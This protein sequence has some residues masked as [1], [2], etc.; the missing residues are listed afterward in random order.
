MMST[1]PVNSSVSRK[2][3]LL[4]SMWYLPVFLL[5][6]ISMVIPGSSIGQNVKPVEVV[7][8]LDMSGSMWRNRP[9]KSVKAIFAWGSELASGNDR[10]GV[11]TLGDKGRVARELEEVG[12][13][14]IRGLMHVL[15][16]RSNRTDVAAGLEQAYYMLKTTSRPGAKR[17][18][19]L[20]S[21]GRID[22]IGGVSANERSAQYVNEIL[23]PSMK[24]EKIQVFALVPEGRSADY[25]FLQGITHRTNGEYFHGLSQD[26]TG[27]RASLFAVPLPMDKAA[28]VNISPRVE[29][30]E[31]VAKAVPPK[32]A[33]AAS[34]KVAKAAAPK[35]AK[36]AA[37]EIPQGGPHASALPQETASKKQFSGQLKPEEVDNSTGST[38]LGFWG[39]GLV[40]VVLASAFVFK[41]KRSRNQKES[42][43]EILKDVQGMR[44]RMS[45]QFDAESERLRKEI[46]EL[47][48][49]V[50]DQSDV[51]EK[52][53]SLSF[54]TPF[55]EFSD[56]DESSSDE[57]G[58]LS[59]DIAS[60]PAFSQKNAEPD[61]SV[62]MMETLIGVSD[63][64]IE[65]EK[66][67]QSLKKE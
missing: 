54:V 32:V 39:L 20:F 17:V 49:D 24:K 47:E 61:M 5:V 33:K 36:A 14:G 25:P 52:A 38:S 44:G 26:A 34:P 64:D 11:V 56:M 42:L 46:T 18:I 59:D 65:N 67:A 2:K 9:W 30:P 22:L 21:D 57:E 1:M 23:I 45:E 53:L 8:V 37:S 40:I 16:E 55:L 28:E 12:E 15:T 48:D 31:K 19:I 35:V 10:V 4:S 3:R 6:V 62:G 43:S 58:G 41:M 13:S 51:S 7:L 63:I 66:Q 27:F 29:T 50:A 60:E